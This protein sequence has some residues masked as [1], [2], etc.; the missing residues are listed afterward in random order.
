[1]D[2]ETFHW[3]SNIVYLFLE[4][5]GSADGTTENALGRKSRKK[6]RK[7]F[8]RSLF[9]EKK[10]I[11]SSEEVADEFCFAG[12]QIKKSVKALSFPYLCERPPSFFSEEDI[13]SQPGLLLMQDH[14]DECQFQANQTSSHASTLGRRE[15]AWTNF[16]QAKETQLL[17]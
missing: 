16:V 11:R 10:K 9:H 13:S 8:H 14:P 12:L 5:K 6:L 15:K 17:L 3:F 1:M 7:R 4:L 2:V